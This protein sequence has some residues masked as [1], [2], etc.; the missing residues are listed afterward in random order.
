MD[1]QTRQ[2]GE[3]KRLSRRVLLGGTAVGG[4][5]ILLAACG[6][7]A[8]TPAEETAPAEKDAESK[9]EMAPK[10]EPQVLR[11]S[12]YHSPEDARW[13]ALSQTFAEGA[14]ALGITIETPQE[15]REVW[16]KRTTEFAAGT[17]TVD[18]T[19]NQNNWALGSAACSSRC[20]NYSSPAMCR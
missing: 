19:Y 2:G 14:E 8:A 10:A 12:N 16:Q 9:A 13:T 6:A 11:I 20:F 17:T 7:V 15:Y 18:I 1:T 4:T 3:Q 5:G